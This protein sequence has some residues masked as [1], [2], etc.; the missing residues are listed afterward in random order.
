MG[1]PKK[2]ENKE[3]SIMAESEL[4][5][6]GDSQ[7]CIRLMAIIQAGE[8]SVEDV[9]KDFKVSPRTIFR[10]MNNFKSSGITGLKGGAKGHRHSKLSDEHKAE[11][12]NWVQLGINSSG[13]SISWTL[14]KLRAEIKSEF[15]VEISIMPLWLHLQKMGCEIKKQSG[16]T[17]KSGL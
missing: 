7:L 13:E 11:I 10:W 6:I 2:N 14:E 9:A 3:L 4:N 1:R 15:N 8:R 16:K 17:E 12:R 5:Q